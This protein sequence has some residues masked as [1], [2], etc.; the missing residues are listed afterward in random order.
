MKQFHIKQYQLH[1]KRNNKCDA[2][3]MRLLAS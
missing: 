1:I 3:R 2:T